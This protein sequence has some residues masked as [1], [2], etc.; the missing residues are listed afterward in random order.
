MTPHEETSLLISAPALGRPI[1]SDG[2]RLWE[3]CLGLPKQLSHQEGWPCCHWWGKCTF[4]TLI[5][6]IHYNTC[7]DVWLYRLAHTWSTQKSSMIVCG[8]SS[9]T[10]RGRRGRW[11][12]QT[13]VKNLLE[14]GHL[15]QISS[16]SGTPCGDNANKEWFW[17]N[18][19][20][21]SWDVWCW[22]I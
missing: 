20:G 21:T 19:S 10:G 15:F 8:E 7:F 3:G 4:F 13:S 2:G 12:K 11:G 1:H 5:F 16:V 6:H 22:G 18:A 14:L 9:E 17:A